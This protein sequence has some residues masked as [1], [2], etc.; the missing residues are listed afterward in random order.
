MNDIKY[1]QWMNKEDLDESL[2]KEMKAMTLSERNDAFSSALQF[3][4]AGMRGI[5]GP[6]PNRMNIYT[7]R[8]ATAGFAQYLLNT[9]KQANKHGVAIGYD[10]RH[11]S[12]NFAVEAGKVL[13]TYGIPSFIFSSLRPTPMLSFA[14]RE[15]NCVGG[16]MITASHNPKEYNGYKVYDLTGCQLVP[17]D[18]DQVIACINAIEDELAIEIDTSM[19]AEKLIH[20][21]PEV[22]DFNYYE[23]VLNIR[24][25]KQLD[26]KSFKIV[27]SPQHGTGLEPIKIALGK[28]GY[29]LIIVDEQATVD[30]DFSNT[31][32]PNPE[33]AK[34]YDLA[35]RY[36][37]QHEAPLIIT[38]DPDADRMGIAVLHQGEYQLFSG[39]QIGAVLLEYM[40][41]QKTWLKTLPRNAVMINTVVTSDLGAKVAAK[42]GVETE[43]TLTGFKYI[44][45]KIEQ[46]QQDKSK[47]FIFGY[48]ESYGYL[49]EPFVRDKDAIQ[50]ALMLAEASVF[51]HLQGK[52]LVDVLNDLYQEHGYYLQRQKSITLSGI[53]GKAKI[54]AIMDWFK[55]YQDNVFATYAITRKENY[56]TQQAMVGDKVELL[57]LPATDLVKWYFDFGWIAIR[58]SGTEP[59]CKIYFCLNGKDAD[60]T[61]KH[62][63]A[64]VAA[65]DQVV[66]Q[67]IG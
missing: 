46:Y 32:S 4:T 50:A 29:Q 34:A 54:T 60:Q 20:E 8:K 58:P 62:Y 59:K 66:N 16:I 49:I 1:Q 15:L 6:G 35:I 14:V 18:S 36:A 39:D 47:T 51:Y 19:S 11:Q 41:S 43:K 25:N 42:Y 64:L 55:A 45:S 65:I 10:N 38:T 22:V 27:Y 63:Q 28:A 21:V 57:D 48:E 24:I 37:R 2:R 3:G 12:K 61:E 30:P 5:L 33:D 53:E 23:R 56:L 13:A 17:A 44:G 40:L 67:I 31:L 52:T 7:V 26:R 9:Q